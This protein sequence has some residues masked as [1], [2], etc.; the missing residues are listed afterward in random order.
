MQTNYKK[1][2]LQIAMKNPKMARLMLEASK[3][4][5]G[6]SK[7][8]QARN[9]LNSLVATQINKMQKEMM[10]VMIMNAKGKKDG[11]G[12]PVDGSV[13]LMPQ[14]PVQRVIVKRLKPISYVPY[15]FKPKI[16]DKSPSGQGGPKYDG[17]GAG[18]PNNSLY[19]INEK[20]GINYG[21]NQPSSQPTQQPSP[22]PPLPNWA[23]PMSWLKGIGN[24]FKGSSKP[25]STLKQETPKQETTTTTFDPIQN[26]KDL[27]ANKGRMNI[28][29]TPSETIPPTSETENL[30]S[31][32]D[33]G[34]P[35]PLPVPETIKTPT[36]TV[37]NVPIGPNLDAS[38]KPTTTSTG[39]K[40]TNYLLNAVNTGMG[41]SNAIL[42]VMADSKL[43]EELFPGTPP[44]QIPVGASLAG[45]LN[46]LKDSLI[47]QYKIEDLRD[48]LT[49]QTDLGTTLT[50]D[51]SA[52][53]RGKDEFL[54]S[55][56]TMLQDATDKSL[57]SSLGSDPFYQQSMKQYKDYLTLLKGHTV[58]R[59]TDYLNTAINYQ[60]GQ[61]TKL[62]TAYD[63]A[64]TKV[65]ELYTQ[66]ATLTTEQYNT[67][68]ELLGEMYDNVLQ[69]GSL[70]GFI[71]TA[72]GSIIKNGTQIIGDV[73]RLNTDQTIAPPTDA[74]FREWLLQNKLANPNLSYDKLWEDLANYLTSK[75]LNPS[76]Y[77]EQFWEI[78]HPEGL[79]GY[80]NVSGDLVP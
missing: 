67:V 4:P 52:Y 21:S 51:V 12:G 50:D 72:T 69:R 10:P 63:T 7:R 22:P 35:T 23:N 74:Q 44:E 25:I 54:H 47:K 58:Q 19:N 79:A 65:N 46:K 8:E 29:S 27:V 1:E 71:N 62:Q 38:G 77:D 17:Q 49:K 30:F 53:V 31:T 5:I 64:A 36:T 32:T 11:Q 18:L 33:Y 41:K 34:T 15:D 40:L 66:Q 73:L 55:V 80:K 13:M 42:G 9:V 28:P 37:S 48:N 57:N 2:S 43:L 68:K 16:V 75:G 56:E 70:N 45:Q 60:N 76:N 6:S 20:L 26:I 39:S 24:F 61:V 59:Y 78:L 3:S 14:P